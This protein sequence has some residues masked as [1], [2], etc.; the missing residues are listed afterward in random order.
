MIVDDG[1]SEG[2]N[3]R[4]R[5]WMESVPLLMRE[6]G[7][8]IDRRDEALLKAYLLLRAEHGDCGNE[9][10]AVCRELERAGV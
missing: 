2:G 8:A 4:P 9:D 7:R 6:A 5:D 1:W 10:C 3:W